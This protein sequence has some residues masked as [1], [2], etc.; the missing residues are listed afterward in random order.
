MNENNDI[1]LLPV[2]IG[3]A[4]D[5]LSI[6]DIK[7]DNIKDHRRDN[8]KL[9]YDMLYGKLKCYIETTNKYYNMLK[10]TNSYIW[11]LMDLLRD[12]INI[13]DEKYVKLCKD[14]I[15]SNDVRFR[16]KNKI[17]KLT[18]SL[19]K[20]EKGYKCLKILIDLIDY[21]DNYDFLIKPLCYYTI[22]YDE[23]YIK[24]DDENMI[25]FI[26]NEFNMSIYI[27]NSN[28]KTEDIEFKKTF[29]ITDSL[30]I[31]SILDI[32]DDDIKRFI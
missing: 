19:I 3:E 16:I 11:N 2:S 15:I 31:N 24:S 23:I 17:N 1:L 20:E 32:N 12:G 13:N 25:D 18:K 6:L 9:E 27:I 10:K 4:L 5:K 7:L 29:Y 22:L 21:K 28:N 30:N 26:N 14:T 8:V